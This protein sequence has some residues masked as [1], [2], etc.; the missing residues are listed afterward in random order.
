MNCDALTALLPLLALGE[1]SAADDV[2]DHLEGCE[3]CRARLTALERTRAALDHAT[4]APEA[5]I[6]GPLLRLAAAQPSRV[7]RLSPIGVA[8]AAA[9]LV[10]AVAAGHWGARLSPAAPSVAPPPSDALPARVV[11]DALFALEE[12]LVELELRHDRD[13]LAL[14][15]AVDRQHLRRDRGVAEQLDLLARA[16]RA[17]LAFTRGAL[18]D[19]ARSIP[20][21]VVPARDERH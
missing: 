14:A 1:R 19:V 9:L 13:L 11:A 2:R 4:V 17:E 18:D 8:A 10:A 20:L 6:P 7:R 15:L 3:R 21:P 5:P 12:R 16:T